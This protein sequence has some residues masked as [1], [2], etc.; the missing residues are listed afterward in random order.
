MYN[1]KLEAGEGL[2]MRAL[3]G[4]SGLVGLISERLK[5]LSNDRRFVFI[6]QRLIAPANPIIILHNLSCYRTGSDF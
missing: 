6:P 3:E 2:G 5:R 1:G 4:Q